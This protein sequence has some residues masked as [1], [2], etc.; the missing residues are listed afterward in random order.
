M[1]KRV[2][3]PLIA[4]LVV[5]AA[6]VALRSE[7]PHSILIDTPM[8]APPWARL[9]RQVLTDSLPACLEFYR[10]YYDDKGRVQCVLRWG[11]DD[12][13]DDAF[14]N[15]AGWP[16]LHALGGADEILTRCMTAH[17]GMI[18]QYTEA[19]TTEVPAGKGGMYYKECS[20]QADWMHHGEGLRVFNRMAL[21]AP[22]D[23]HY[24]ARARRFAGFYMGEDAEAPNY[25]SQRKLIRSLINGSRGPLLRQA[26][27]IDWVGDPIDIT[28]FNAA[29]GERSF[30]EML[31]HYAE[32]GEVVGDSFLNL[33]A[34]TLP[35]DA[36]LVTGDARYRRWIVDYMDAW[37]DRMASNGGIIPSFVDLEGRIGGPSGRWWGNAYG[38]G[39]SPVNP[40]TGQR[41]NRNRIPRALVG[42]NNALW[43]TGDQ[44]YVD[45]WRRMIS[46][47]N[48]NARTV[49]GRQQYP[50]MYGESGWY[51]WQ[52]QPW[53]VGA[54]EIWY[55]S[56][57]ADDLAR[58]ANDPWVRYLQGQ[59]PAY[60]ETALQADL[61]AMRTRV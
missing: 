21:S 49:D 19:T 3:R 16:E 41:E 45:A 50:T 4:S 34:T 5:C 24:V 1:M 12:G 48:A 26:T 8:T 10:K 22:A 11:A 31:A 2:A 9:E 35:L 54:L 42:F 6:G 25:D 51:G 56:M 57:G 20:A 43:V 60:P 7:G 27:P 37:L 36:Y 47:V 28:K 23:P 18:A 33:V 30:D 40:V 55:W 39:F 46:A 44:K 17:D 29:H 52:A 59:N 32:Y 58:V 38:W 53:N 61:T 14:E 15:V 13:P